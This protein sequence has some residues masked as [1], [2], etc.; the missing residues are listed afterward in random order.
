M[1]RVGERL[2]EVFV[3]LHPSGASACEDDPVGNPPTGTSSDQTIVHRSLLDGQACVVCTVDIGSGAVSELY[4]THELLL[5]AP[6]WTSSGALILNGNGV[7]WR[8]ERGGLTQLVIPG[9]PGLNNDHVPAPDGDTMF[10]SGYDGHIH[11]VALSTGEHRQVTSD[12]PERPMHHFLHG[13]DPHGDEIAFVGVEPGTDSPWGPANIFTMPSDGGPVH[14]VTFGDRPADG[15]E[16]S[17]DGEWIYFNTEAF[18]DTEGHAQIAR[19]RRDGT[20]L[21]Q[22]TFDERVNWFPHLAPVGNVACY[23]SYPPGTTGHPEN[24]TVQLELVEGDDWSSASTIVELF[25]G[26]GTINVNSWSPDGR[27]FAFV[28]YPLEG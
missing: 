4:R 26:Q 20:G 7:L 11:R 10:V 18:S 15:P 21:E 12:D 25:G 5:E 2:E 28:A 8:L 6:N 1:G 3:R 23:L 17:P 19:I 9:L 22:L 24:E 14:Q 13:V 16:Y 27:A